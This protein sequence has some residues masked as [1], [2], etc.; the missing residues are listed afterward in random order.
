MRRP[1]KPSVSWRDSRSLPWQENIPVSAVA[2]LMTESDLEDTAP[3]TLQLPE[4]EQPVVFELLSWA[5]FLFG[6]VVVYFGWSELGP[7]AGHS[8]AF[9]LVAWIFIPGLCL[10]GLFCFNHFVVRPWKY[11][12]VC[13]AGTLEAWSADQAFGSSPGQVIAVVHRG[14]HDHDVVPKFGVQVRLDNGTLWT[15]RWRHHPPYG[16][17]RVNQ[18]PRVGSA[19]RLWRMSDSNYVI[20]V[21]DPTGGYRSE[22][23]P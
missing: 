7:P 20:E 12:S 1:V 16:R 23:R 3:T 21:I 13:D 17:I 14:H 2:H 22:Q 15:A 4:R 5:L 18:V 11:Q 6:L 10:V 9:S 19:A 8:L